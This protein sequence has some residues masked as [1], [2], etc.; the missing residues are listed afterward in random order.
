[1]QPERIRVVAGFV[2]ATPPATRPHWPCPDHLDTAEL[3]QLVLH[4]KRSVRGRSDPPARRGD[5]PARAA[6][7]PRSRPVDRARW[8]LL[9]LAR[10]GPAELERDF[11]LR[12]AQALRLSAAFA[13]GRRTARFQRVPRGPIRSAEQI[14]ALFGGELA[15]LRQE[16][17][18][19]VALDGR[20]GFLARYEVSRGTLTASL[21]HPREVFRPA[22]A[23]GAGALVVLHN[24][25]SGNPEPSGDDLAVTR[26]LI[27]AGDLLGVPL[28]DHVIVGAGSRVSLRERMPWS[29]GTGYRETTRDG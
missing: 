14:T 27:D 19:A 16:R 1:M 15:G 9:E 2:S 12:P 24:H 20:H 3:V 22:L 7:H 8:D 6:R 25:P 23:R 29:E 5:L 26:R 11:A 18:H 10:A 13:L 17:L 4:G 21:V 28:L